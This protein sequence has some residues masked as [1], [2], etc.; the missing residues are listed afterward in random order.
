MSG[1]LRTPKPSLPPRPLYEDA[2]VKE[3]RVK[4]KRQPAARRDT[5]LSGHRKS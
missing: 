5:N 3:R 2:E 1:K 4:A